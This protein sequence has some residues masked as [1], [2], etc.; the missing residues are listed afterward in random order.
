MQ[1]R[2]IQYTVKTNTIYSEDKYNIQQQQI[3]YPVIINDNRFR[4]MQYPITTNH[5]PL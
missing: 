2:Q 5:Y 1:G 4:Q 3:Q